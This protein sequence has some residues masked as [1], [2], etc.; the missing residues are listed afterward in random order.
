MNDMFVIINKKF[1]IQKKILTTMMIVNMTKR[2]LGF[3][4][5]LITILMI[6]RGI[7]CGTDMSVE[8]TNHEKMINLP[9]RI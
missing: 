5:L 1:M 3:I 8:L 6:S 9:S 2:T 4:M 7:V